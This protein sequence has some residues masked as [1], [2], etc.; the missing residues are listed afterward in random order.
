MLQKAQTLLGAGQLAEAGTSFRNVLLR[1]P[2]NWISMN[3]LASIALQSDELEEAI[4]RY[5]ALTERRP[6]F[7]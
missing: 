7:A 4:Q 3:A 6:D 2:R 5:S 1:D